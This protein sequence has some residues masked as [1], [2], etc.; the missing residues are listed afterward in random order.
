M[1]S[2]TSKTTSPTTTPP[3][4]E[5]LHGGVDVGAK[6]TKLVAVETKTRNVI[7]SDYRRHNALQL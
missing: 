3:T 4:P 6:T 1:L 2:A 5:L 7:F